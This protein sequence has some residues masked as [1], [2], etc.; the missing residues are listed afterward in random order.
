MIAPIFSGLKQSCQL[1]Q[2]FP[3][4]LILEAMDADKAVTS[5]EVGPR[6]PVTIAMSALDDISSS[7]ADIA[8]PS[9]PKY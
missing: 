3:Q 7:I 5:S 8:H 4:D 6:P 2:V 1:L 9:S